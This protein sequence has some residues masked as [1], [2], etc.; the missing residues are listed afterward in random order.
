MV[1]VSSV[2]SSRVRTSSRW[3]VILGLDSRRCG[4]AFR[5][6]DAVYGEHGVAGGGDGGGA[7]L[8]KP[9]TR[10]RKELAKA[11][12]LLEKPGGGVFGLLTRFLRELEQTELG[13]IGGLVGLGGARWAHLIE[14][15][16]A[17]RGG[18]LGGRLRVPDLK[19]SAD[20]FD[21]FS[22]LGRQGRELVAGDAHGAPVHHAVG[23]D[24]LVEGNGGG[25]PLEDVPLEAAAAFGYGDGGDAGEEGFADSLPSGFGVD[26]EVFEVNGGAAPGGVDGEE[27]GEGYGLAV[28]FGEEAAVA[29]GVS[30][31]AAEAIAEEFG[32]GE[33][34]LVWLA[35]VFGEGSDE[36]EDLGDVGGGGLAELD[37]DGVLGHSAI[38]RSL[39]VGVFGG[40]GLVGGFGG[41]FGLGG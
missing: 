28:E 34:D 40:S 12:L 11:H 9:Q 6:L 33:D 1:R 24:G 35:L 19:A 2:C 20:D 14:V 17:A 4:D 22:C 7:S 36:G 13:E 37:C 25:V 8:E 39:V 18:G 21:S 26:E 27:E 15:D 41:G 5:E 10:R 29:G 16:L 23:S 31:W 38:L 3:M 30:I 32:L